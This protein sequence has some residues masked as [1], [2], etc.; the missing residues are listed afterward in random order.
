MFY[1]VTECT[2]SES[3]QETNGCSRARKYAV[4]IYIHVKKSPHIMTTKETQQ[5]KPP[6]KCSIMYSLKANIYMI[7]H[8]PGGNLKLLVKN[9]QGPHQFPITKQRYY[10]ETT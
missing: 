1:P 6:G 5:R 7:E 3:G 10:P 8:F 2:R 4:R 9:L